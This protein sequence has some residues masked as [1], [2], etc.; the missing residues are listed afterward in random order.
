MSRK[1]NN[2]VLRALDCKVEG[3]IN[4]GKPKKTWMKL[5]EEEGMKVGQSR[6]EAD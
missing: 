1:E 6:E 5:I 3:Q 2:H 4:K